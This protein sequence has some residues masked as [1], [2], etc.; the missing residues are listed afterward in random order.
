MTVYGNL[1]LS[2][3]F[4]TWNLVLRLGLTALARGGERYHQCLVKNWRLGI[5]KYSERQRFQQKWTD[6]KK[7]V[8]PDTKNIIQLQ[9]VAELGSIEVAYFFFASQT[10]LPVRTWLVE[11]RYGA[12][13]NP[14]YRSGIIINFVSL[15]L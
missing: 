14:H 9:V 1:S 15:W 13:T 10:Q 8:S 4:I 3:F 11:V 7:Y 12:T 5:K 6:L 2:K